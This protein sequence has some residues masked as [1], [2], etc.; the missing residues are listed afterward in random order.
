MSHHS[1]FIRALAT[2]AL[3]AVASTSTAVA[4]AAPCADG[5]QM[6]D[7]MSDQMPGADIPS[8]QPEAEAHSCCPDEPEPEGDTRVSAPDCCAGGA[9]LTC[10]GPAL[11]PT[12]ATS[13]AHDQARAVADHWQ[14]GPGTTVTL[15]RQALGPPG[16][17]PTSLPPPG[18]RYTTTT[19]VLL[20]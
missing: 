9:A 4:W 1:P 10:A 2:L 14:P 17:G 7:E 19:V 5:C 6:P 11:V 3:I 8:D 18:E 20:I 15:E 16:Y 12:M 13:L